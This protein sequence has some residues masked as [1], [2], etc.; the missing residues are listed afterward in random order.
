[1]IV[2]VPIGD[3]PTA[4]TIHPISRRIRPLPETGV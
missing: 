4:E 1:M 2:A 3:M